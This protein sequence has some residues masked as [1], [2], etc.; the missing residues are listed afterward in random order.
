[1]FKIGLVGTGIIAD[2][3]KKAIAKNDEVTITAVC[4]ID[5]QKAEN[6]AEGINASIYTDYKEMAEKESLDCV[7]LNLPHFLH[8]DVTVY[9]LNK[10]ISV[11][12][13]KPMANT[14][15]ECE[16]MIEAASKTSAKFGIGH[17]Q[18]YFDCYRMVKDIVD[19][20]TL[21]KL[22]S[23]TETRNIHY[24]TD[25]RPKWFLDKKLAGGGIVMNYCAHT[26]D[27]IFYATGLEVEDLHA[28]GNNFVSDDDVEA[29][30]QVLLRFKGGVTAALTYCG[31]K[32]P[33]QYDTYFYFTEGTVA[34]SK[35]GDTMRIQ[36]LGR[37]DEVYDFNTDDIFER[38]IAELVKMLKG[39]EN[40]IVTPQTGKKIIAVNE[41]IVNMI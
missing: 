22:C 10:G 3:H 20:N 41:K 15:A 23:I 29:T 14:V 28:F 11:L 36:R 34:I 12:V 4:D 7:I 19:K 6:A 27:K 31:A 9:F 25:V 5:I 13:E 24:F 35:G 37:E 1:M 30:C 18:K 21:G 2:F 17:V 16:E 32:V 33:T 40:E 38:Q 8:R 26:M 39:E